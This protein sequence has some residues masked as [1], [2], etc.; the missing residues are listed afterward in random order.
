MNI[1]V[2]YRLREKPLQRPTVAQGH[3]ALSRAL[4]QEQTPRQCLPTR[5]R[6]SY[7]ACRLE[8]CRFV[9][10]R[11]ISGVHFGWRSCVDFIFFPFIQTFKMRSTFKRSDPKDYNNLP[12]VTK[13]NIIRE[14][15]TQ[16]KLNTNAFSSL[17]YL[18]GDLLN[19]IAF[20]SF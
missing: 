20:S 16:I 10:P 3:A 19:Y 6:P 2:V 8:L 12:T 18:K 15:V 7:G 5:A 9:I 13:R 11:V 1:G 14:I 4:P 17:A